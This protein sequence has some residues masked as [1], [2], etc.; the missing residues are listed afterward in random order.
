MDSRLQD[1]YYQLVR[2]HEHVLNEAASGLSALPGTSQSFACTQAMWRFLGN[3]S[4]SLSALIEPIQETA[5]P[6]LAGGRERVA[7][8]AHDWSMLN[9][10]AHGSKPD[11]YQRTHK[12]DLGYDLATALLIEPDRGTPLGPME[13][14]LR[15]AQGVLTT[16]PGGATAHSSHLDELIDVMRASR[17]WA[18]D[19]PAVHIIDRE[20]DSVWHYRLWHAAG[21]QFVV[22]ADDQRLVR[23]G[24]VEQPLPG[25]AKALLE[26]DAFAETGETI[27]YKGTAGRLQVAETTI[28]LDRP[29]QRT[30]LGKKK[31]IP[32]E[33]IPLRLVVCRVVDANDP[34]K[35]LA[36][37][38]L[39]TNVSGLY[40]A[41]TVVRWYYWR[42]R[43]ET[44]HKLLKSSGQQIEEWEQGSG[45][46]IAR[47]LVIAS[48]AC[49]TV[50]ALQHDESPAAGELR[51]V[52]IRLSGRQMKYKVESTAPALLAGLEKM[53]A[54]LD[55]LEHH[56]IAELR[57]LV[58]D[59]LPFLFNSS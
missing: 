18:L 51:R 32:G 13:I 20:A 47:R 19:R 24:G 4:V 29:A 53:L 37:W 27:D 48:M 43:I 34:E 49:L 8:I 9:Y 15:T 45:E 17:A 26:E 56:D 35:E 57:R 22:R 12:N 44:Y 39:L 59:K 52:L 55:L 10:G 42:W 58:R 14:R 3:K 33:P 54:M 6:I 2:E 16:R 46:A 5:R 41:A 11:R 21:H 23:R 50:W 38:L 7:L 1:R 28:V 40:D 36:R 31:S 25:V 30:V